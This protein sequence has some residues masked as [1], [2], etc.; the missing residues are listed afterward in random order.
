MASFAA[1]EMA[2]DRQVV[3]VRLLRRNRL[4]ALLRWLVPLVGLLLAVLVVGVIALDS[5]RNRFGIANLTLDR[6]RMVVDAPRLSSMLPDGTVLTLSAG[7][8]SASLLSA[9]RIAL[10][11]AQL[12]MSG[13]DAPALMAEAPEADLDTTAQLLDVPG[14]TGF[15]SMSGMSGE[16]LGLVADLAAET[17][18]SG[19]VDLTMADGTNLRAETMTYDHKAQ[20]WTFGRV[21][22]SMP[23]TPGGQP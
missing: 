4:V 6:D 12:T 11:D 3:R 9:D 10:V 14:V 17:A 7:A 2:D 13:E 22:V 15:T 5:L 20:L 23:F 19:P 18:S 1:P 8:A 16:A 21:T